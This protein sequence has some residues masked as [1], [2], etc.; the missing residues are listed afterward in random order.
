MKAKVK[1]YMVAKQQQALNDHNL[2]AFTWPWKKHTRIA[3][4]GDTK[5]TY[6]ER[7]SWVVADPE[8]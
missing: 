2:R 7:G 3:H 6:K 8:Q 4:H 5:Q 1:S